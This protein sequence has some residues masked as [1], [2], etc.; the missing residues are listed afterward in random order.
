MGNKCFKAP[1]SACTNNGTLGPDCGGWGC[2]CEA[3]VPS[4]YETRWDDAINVPI[5]YSCTCQP[6]NSINVAIAFFVVA[7][8]WKS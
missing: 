8:E 6:K 1:D 3:P 4:I 7:G 2:M 5:S